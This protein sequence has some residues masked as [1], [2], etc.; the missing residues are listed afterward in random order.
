MSKSSLVFLLRDILLPDTT[1]RV[2][3]FSVVFLCFSGVF[4]LSP[5]MPVFDLDIL[6]FSKHHCI[7]P[8][9]LPKGNL[10]GCM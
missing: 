2:D 8:P 6:L 4:T 1:R 7:A 9:L 10:A 5:S 3:G